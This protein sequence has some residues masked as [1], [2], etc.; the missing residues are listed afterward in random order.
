MIRILNYLL[1]FYSMPIQE[2]SLSLHN[3]QPR[4]PPLLDN[5]LLRVQT[6][7]LVEKHGATD[8]AQWNAKC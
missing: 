8:I 4:V 1:H 3:P 6:P 5:Q 7:I 2:F